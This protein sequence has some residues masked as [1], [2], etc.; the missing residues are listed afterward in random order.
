MGHTPQ[1]NERSA[2]SDLKSHAGRLA[3]QRVADLFEGNAQ[4]AT[5][6][7][8]RGAGLELDY[9]RQ[10]LDAPAL[11]A[12]LA[13]AEEADLPA[14]A[15]ALLSGESVNNTEDRP[16]LHSLLRATNA[17]SGL[18]DSFRG[19]DPGVDEVLGDAHQCG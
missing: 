2:F 3:S 18:E 19:R 14:R 16:A 6:F 15:Q 8:A 12:L 7:V 11:D 9:S 10:L 13:L 5:D 17:P 4:R 1:L